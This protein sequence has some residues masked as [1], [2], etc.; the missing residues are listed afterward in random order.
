MLLFD[1]YENINNSNGL[2]KCLLMENALNY[3]AP[4]IQHFRRDHDLA[5]NEVI[6]NANDRFC[7]NSY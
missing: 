1:V 7:V 4:L 3:H 5:D 6:A 2:F